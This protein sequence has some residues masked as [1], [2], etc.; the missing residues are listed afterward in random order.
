MYMVGFTGHQNLS[1]SIRAFAEAR[2]VD[3]LQ[4]IDSE[5][6]G[7]TSLAGGADQLFAK[8]I[9][10]AQLTL[11]VVIPC[12]RYDESFSTEADLNA[13]HALLPRA[14]EVE[15]LPFQYPS[16]E[17]YFAAGRRIVD[18]SNQL[19]AL[20]DGKPARGLGGTADVVDYAQSQ[21]VVVSKIWPPGKLRP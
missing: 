9:L 16:E 17:A 15:F 5:T 21:H 14:D 13:Y 2:I 4:N 1:R 3:L 20:W 12:E 8:C 18:R 10:S 11:K 19:I 7:L 6:A